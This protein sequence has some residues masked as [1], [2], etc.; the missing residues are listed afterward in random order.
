MGRSFEMLSA[1]RV[2]NSP[3]K[4]GPSAVS[5]RAWGRAFSNLGEI[6]PQNTEVVHG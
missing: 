1:Q 6:S 5:G 2:T 4:G 3:G